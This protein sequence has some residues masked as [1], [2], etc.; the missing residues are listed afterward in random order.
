[1]KK[2]LV[3]ALSILTLLLGACGDE[4]KSEEKEKVEETTIDTTI[5]TTQAATDYK[6]AILVDLTAFVED[7]KL[8]QTHINEG[9]LEDASELYPLLHM[10][11]E[12]FK[13]LQNQFPDQFTR[14]DGQTEDGK[15]LEGSGLHAIEYG[16]FVQKDVLG[17]STIATNLAE[18]AMEL[19]NDVAKAELNGEKLLTSTENMLEFVVSD[20]LT[21]K[22]K[23]IANTQVYDVK[24][25]VDAVTQV[26]Q[27]FQHHA[28]TAELKALETTL[29][30]VNDE[31]A[32]YEVG[33]EDYV[34]FTYF[35]NK[36]KEQLTEQ[37]NLLV[38]DFATFKKAI[39]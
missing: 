36:Q 23:N 34:N 10:S 19:A 4:K 1:M 31:I 37:M 6:T 28:S 32:F 27:A 33:K 13:P 25:N 26:M 14:I 39:K 21:G 16:L 38:E 15:E 12:K 22:E 9:K 18:A 7:V 5:D 8:L 30:K 2:R 35:T 17:L 11:F 20:K 3:V 24:G 29:N